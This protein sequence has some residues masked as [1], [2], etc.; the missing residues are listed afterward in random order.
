MAF[1]QQLS[2]VRLA[3]PPDAPPLALVRARIREALSDVPAARVADI[4]LAATELVTNAYA[5]GRPPISFRL[6]TAPDG[7]LRLEVFDSGATLP[8]V[9][10]LDT[11][12]DGGRGLLLVQALSGRWGTSRS[13][14]GKT[15]W[16][17]FC[18]DEERDPDPV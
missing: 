1:D 3:M 17:E 2:E 5:H 11:V 8:E 16:A 4:E 9:R 6:C 13:D 18:L 12:R 7:W 10:P 14:D 15:V